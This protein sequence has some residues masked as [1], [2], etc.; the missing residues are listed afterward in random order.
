MNYSWELQR[1]QSNSTVNE[2]DLFIKANSSWQSHKC[3]SQGHVQCTIQRM[4][5][6]FSIQGS[7]Q[8]NIFSMSSFIKPG[9]KFRKTEV[10][11]I[12]DS[13]LQN[14]GYQ[15]GKFAVYV[16]TCHGLRWTCDQGFSM[17]QQQCQYG[18]RNQDSEAQTHCQ[19]ILLFN[20]FNVVHVPGHQWGA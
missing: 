2:W 11:W 7:L 14:F 16:E 18:T 13:Y 6:D 17:H 8:A 5:K 3:I 1:G 19:D 15:H 9:F 4:L 12:G 20:G 10:K